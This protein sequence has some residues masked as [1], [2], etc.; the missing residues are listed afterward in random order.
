MKPRDRLL[1]RN[2]LRLV[3]TRKSLATVADCLSSLD[4]DTDADMYLATLIE[5]LEML[6]Q[7]DTSSL[8]WRQ[9]TSTL[10]GHRMYGLER[11]GMLPSGEE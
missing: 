11:I 4:T 5:E 6:K 1:Q 2:P 10:D 9:A 8:A 7:R 3:V